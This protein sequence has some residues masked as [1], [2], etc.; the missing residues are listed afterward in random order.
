MVERDPVFLRRCANHLSRNEERHARRA[1]RPSPTVRHRRRRSPD[2]AGQYGGGCGRCEADR[3]RIA[4][5]V[6]GAE[7]RRVAG[8]LRDG[9]TVRSSQR[10][11][12]ASV[13]DRR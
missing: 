7:E 5:R 9:G 13:E 4:L 11:A 6:L 1:G 12:T 2:G 3:R 8:G 10:R